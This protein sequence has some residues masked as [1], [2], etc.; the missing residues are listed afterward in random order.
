M[1]KIH[2]PLNLGIKNTFDLVEKLKPSIYFELSK[3]EKLKNTEG[4]NTKDT[5][6]IKAVV[7]SLNK[8]GILSIAM[9]YLNLNL[10]FIF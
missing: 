8:G 7:C 4:F 5:I 3:L 6:E 10:S 9:A 2:N 1:A